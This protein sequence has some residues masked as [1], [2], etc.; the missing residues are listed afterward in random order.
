VH[1][2]VDA[3]GEED[4]ERDAALER[5]GDDAAPLGRGSL[6]LEDGNETG[7]RADT[8]AGEDTAG[9]ELA[10]LGAGR[11]L[12]GDTGK[13]KDERDQV[14]RAE[15]ELAALWARL[16]NTVSRGVA[17]WQRHKKRATNEIQPDERAP[18]KQ[19]TEKIPVMTLV[20]EKRWGRGQRA[21]SVEFGWVRGCWR[22]TGGTS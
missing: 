10:V 1:A 16:R 8:V 22:T 21:V 14:G 19:P 9:D 6:G 18:T 13:E 4:A 3:V 11:D 12:D 7:E 5:T 17:S 2:L 15:A 20:N